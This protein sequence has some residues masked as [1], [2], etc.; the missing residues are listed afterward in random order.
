[1]MD[2]ALSTLDETEEDVLEAIRS[3]LEEQFPVSV[4]RTPAPP[5]PA[6]GWDEKRRQYSAPAVLE[7]LLRSNSSAD[8]HLAIT[9]A[10]LFIPMLTFVYG[11]AQLGGKG[12]LVS[13]ARLRQEFYSLPPNARL[14]A[15]RARKEA[16]HE[17][18][19]LFGLVH[20]S[21]DQCAM[22]LSTNISQLDRKGEGLCL[23]CAARV[24]EF[25]G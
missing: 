5:L 1:M 12:A 18:G 24:K 9:K 14:L 22:R 16:V 20:C 11:Q 8:K 19:H 23:A 25:V 6:A 21:A 4:R 2:M 17:T 10:D 3:A 15:S 13:L 7:S